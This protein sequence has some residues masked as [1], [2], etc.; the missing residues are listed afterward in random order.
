MSRTPGDAQLA[1]G[2]VVCFR[3]ER[4]LTG[5]QRAITY[6]VLN[7]AQ[8]SLIICEDCI[9]AVLGSL[10]QDWAEHLRDTEW[11]WQYTEDRRQRVVD[12]AQEVA[13]RHS[14]DGTFVTSDDQIVHMA[15]E[16]NQMRDLLE[17][18]RLG[19]MTRARMD[20]ELEDFCC[21]GDVEDLANR[22]VDANKRI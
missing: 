12:A 22:L 14:S 15:R 16:Y 7:E 6:H 19:I 4:E 11:P 20:R 5:N 13:N 2:P 1:P 3:C 18:I 9:P 8:H 21:R 10:V 17:R